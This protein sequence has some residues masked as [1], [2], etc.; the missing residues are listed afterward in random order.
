[1][2]SEKSATRKT[3]RYLLYG[4]TILFALIGFFS[5]HRLFCN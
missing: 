2:N 3:L 4:L 1:M 5:D